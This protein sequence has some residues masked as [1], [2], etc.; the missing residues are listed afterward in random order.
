MCQY[1]RQ[2]YDLSCSNRAGFLLH[3]KA[4][5]CAALALTIPSFIFFKRVV[6]IVFTVRG[7]RSPRAFAI[8]SRTALLAYP[9]KCGS[10]LSKAAN[11]S[12]F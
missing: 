10:A 9:S 6:E 1:T 12:A 3:K 8:A 5:T 2:A 4:A 11:N 7:H